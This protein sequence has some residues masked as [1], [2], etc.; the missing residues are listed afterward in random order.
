MTAAKVCHD[1]H[2]GNLQPCAEHARK[3]WQDSDRGQRLSSRPWERVRQFVLDRDPVC[4]IC[5]NA[6]SVEVDHIEQGD[7]MDPADLQGVCVP[8]HKAKTQREAQR[9]RA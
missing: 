8:C 3:P 7:S 2:C 9:A 6:P 4:C 5:T 1:P